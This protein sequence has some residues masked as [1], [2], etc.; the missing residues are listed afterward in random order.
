MAENTQGLSFEFD[1]VSSGNIDT[2][3]DSFDAVYILDLNA[4]LCHVLKSFGT[5]NGGAGAEDLSELVAATVRS[6][7]SSEY[8]NIVLEFTDI[9][10]MAS[11]LSE[12]N[13]LGTDFL[14][15]D[16]I[17]RRAAI[18]PF[19]RD[20]NGMI[21]KAIFAIRNI[22]EKKRLELEYDRQIKIGIEDERLMYVEM[23]QLQSCGVFATD[24]DDCIIMINDA[25]ARVFGYDSADDFTGTVEDI[26]NLNEN[27]DLETVRQEIRRLKEEGGELN[28]E[29][30]LMQ[31]C[32]KRVCILAKITGTT[33]SSGERII[34]NSL[35]DITE[36]KKYREELATLAGVDELTG[37]RNYEVGK[38]KV[39]EELD[40]GNVGLFCLLNIDDFK[41]V[42]SKYGREV[43]DKVL[44]TIAGCFQKA[45]RNNDIIMRIR[46]DEFA[47]FASGVDNKLT[48]QNC[49]ARFMHQLDNAIIEGVDMKDVA[50]SLG[51]YICPRDSGNTFDEVYRIADAA[52]YIAKGEEGNYC[53]FAD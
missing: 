26:W 44:I 47:V 23:L 52:L 12:N 34:I 51:G 10:T 33:L 1:G 30:M 43:G 21:S 25:A 32:G 39:R 18:I 46:D 29:F 49:I 28:Y 19:E 7:V 35:T 41:N 53:Y 17:W 4:C 8:V 50:V 11:R 5:E 13:Y 37:T 14:D 42:N 48:A 3:S 40:R 45:F 20:E 27:E 15:A 9:F 2:I 22:D 31:P 24:K 38:K 36:I 6:R 16:K